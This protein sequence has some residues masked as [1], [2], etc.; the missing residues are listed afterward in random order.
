MPVSILGINHKTAPVDMREKVAFSPTTM[1]ESLLSLKSGAKLDEV[2]IISTCN[3]MEIIYRS[4]NHHETEA[5]IAEKSRQ[6]ALWLANYHQ[7]DISQLENFTYCHSGQQAISHIMSVAC[8]LDSMVLGEP[9]I[10]G[11]VK[12]AMLSFDN[13]LMIK[14][15]YENKENIELF[16]DIKMEKGIKAKHSKIL[17]TDMKFKTKTGH[18][19]RNKAEKMI[20]KNS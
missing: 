17:D 3:R 1:S 20:N 15:D 10:L 6:V 8:G 4:E 9:Q 19:V 7:F 16:D 14:K 12:D 13:V 2:A 18:Y 11:Q 5:A